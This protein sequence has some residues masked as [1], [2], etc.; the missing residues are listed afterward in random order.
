M[1]IL[2]LAKFIK[3]EI[4]TSEIQVRMIQDRTDSHLKNY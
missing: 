3:E 1:K 2:D 4:E